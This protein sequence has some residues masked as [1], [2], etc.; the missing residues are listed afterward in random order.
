M[1]FNR[2]VTGPMPDPQ[3]MMVPV[4]SRRVFIL[5]MLRNASIA[6]GV[7]AAGLFIG[8]SGYHWI[9]RLDWEESFYYAA[10]I[11]SGEGP[12]P[13]PTLAGYS[14]IRLHIFAGF[15]ALS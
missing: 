11:L 6:I 3:I 8:M 4:P 7:I 10:M 5:R 2:R 9:G 12:P 15:Y 1:P 13:D 14:L